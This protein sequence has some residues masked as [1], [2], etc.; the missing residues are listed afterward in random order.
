MAWL[1]H[2]CS[3]RQKCYE[4]RLAARAEPLAI[5]ERFRKEDGQAAKPLLWRRVP[6]PYSF[7]GYGHQCGNSM[8]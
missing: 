1:L 3:A 2:P 4:E 7:K 5:P 8:H 6:S